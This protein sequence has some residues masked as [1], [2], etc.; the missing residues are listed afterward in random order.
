MWLC[1]LDVGRR[2][3][4]AD[5]RCVLFVVCCVLLF[6]CCLLFAVRCALIVVRWV[7]FVV[8]CPWSGVCLCNQL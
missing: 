3:L 7:F 2:L 8:Y 6:L 1:V 5:V 4:C